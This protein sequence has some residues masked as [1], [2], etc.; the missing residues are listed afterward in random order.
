MTRVHQDPGT[1]LDQAREVCAAGDP[2]RAALR[3]LLA[4]RAYRCAGAKASAIGAYKLAARWSNG[5][6]EILAVLGDAHE[7]FGDSEAAGDAYAR[8]ALRLGP[9]DR[10]L[11]GLLWRRVAELDRQ[12]AQ[13]RLTVAELELEEHGP[14][15]AE[16]WFVEAVCLMRRAE[17][18]TILEIATRAHQLFPR[19]RTLAIELAR[20]WLARGRP[21]EALDTLRAHFQVAPPSPALVKKLSDWADAH[22]EAGASRIVLVAAARSYLEIGRDPEA[23]LACTAILEAYDEDADGATE[24][25]DRSALEAEMARLA[26]DPVTRKVSAMVV[27]LVIAE[28]ARVA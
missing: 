1:I 18:P 24:E 8:A 16:R 12:N 14:A 21:A 4:G 7:S 2:D 28:S 15:A 19:Q 6:P 11:A 27:D 20:V 25:L 3:A 23:R 13:A 5:R 22:P 17:H 9:R 26:E 10:G